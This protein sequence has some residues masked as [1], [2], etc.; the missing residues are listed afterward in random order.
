ML[1]PVLGAAALLLAGY[2]LLPLTMGVCHIG[3]LWPAALGLLAA[4]RCFFPGLFRRMPGWLRWIIR[5]GVTAVLAVTLLLGAAMGLAAADR[6]G[7]DDP[8]APETVVLLGCQ[9]YN[10][11]PSVMLQGR[12][13]AAYVY[14]AAHPEAVCVTTGGLDRTDEPYTEGGCARR[15]LIQM[16]IAPERIYAE[17]KSFDTQENLAFAAR[18]IR[19]NGLDTRVVIAS[20]GFHQLRGQYF[21]REAGLTPQSAA[22]RSPWYLG[23]GYAC[24][25][26]VGIL[27]LTAGIS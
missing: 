17:E 11:R 24:R 16:G 8:D 12:I 20:D 21:A 13:D 10:G 18:I 23:L 14:L 25:E 27:A 6:P 19:E 1:L 5:C 7:E 22:C 2:F 15:D 4:V 9:V 3:M 26:M